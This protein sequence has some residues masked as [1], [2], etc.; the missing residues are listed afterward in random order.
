MRCA[1]SLWV[2]SWR[3][4]NGAII[5]KW[6]QFQ[7]SQSRS[8]ISAFEIRIEI[9][10]SRVELL[11]IQLKSLLYFK[12]SSL[13]SIEIFSNHWIQFAVDLSL[14]LHCLIFLSL[15]SPVQIDV[16]LWISIY[17]TRIFT[18]WLNFAIALSLFIINKLLI[19]KKLIELPLSSWSQFLIK[20]FLAIRRIN[21]REITLL[22]I[23]PD[24]IIRRS[25]ML[26]SPFAFR[27]RPLPPPTLR[28]LTRTLLL[29]HHLLITLTLSHIQP[30]RSILT[31]RRIVRHRRLPPRRIALRL[32]R[33]APRSRLLLWLL[34]LHGPVSG[35]P[36]A[37]ALLLSRILLRLLRTDDSEL[38]GVV[39]P[40]SHACPVISGFVLLLRHVAVWNRSLRPLSK[41]TWL[42]FAYSLFCLPVLVLTTPVV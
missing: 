11:L 17:S 12:V 3:E 25:Q 37:P 22:L 26:L 38:V 36:A 27:L 23:W 9:P 21:R 34:D 18:P 19:L 40:E 2:P 14:V 13:L 6:C 1:V 39:S 33:S 41:P 7:V 32:P 28:P 15:L 30:R 29:L 20:V 10:L 8:W 42:I 24:L 4:G 16:C 5:F 31:L 35:A